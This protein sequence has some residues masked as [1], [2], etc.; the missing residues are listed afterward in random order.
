MNL[1]HNRSKKLYFFSEN[2]KQYSRLLVEM[3]KLRLME[4]GTVEIIPEDLG[5]SVG[6]EIYKGNKDLQDLFHRWAPKTSGDYD[7]TKAG[8]PATD[9]LE[10][11]EAR[12]ERILERLRNRKLTS[13]QL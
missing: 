11:R 3:S 6:G 12:R 2:A 1:L 5:I 13:E 10:S 4:E 8:N 7:L 9:K